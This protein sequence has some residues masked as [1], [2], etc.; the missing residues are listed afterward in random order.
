[1]EDRGVF[2]STRRPSWFSPCASYALARF[3]QARVGAGQ[4]LGMG[5]DAPPRL[6]DGAIELLQFDEAI[7]MET[8]R[9]GL[10]PLA[11]SADSLRYG[12]PAE[13]R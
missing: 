3:E 13:A 10:P 7:R 12:M 11:A 6:L 2:S 8:C 4:A 9:T 1:M 5:G